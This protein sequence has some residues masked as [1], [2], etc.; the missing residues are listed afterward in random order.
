VI[1]IGRSLFQLRLPFLAAVVAFA[2]SGCTPSGFIARQLIRA[3]NTFPRAVAPEPRVYY[4]FPEALLDA[5]P[6]QLATVGSP[7]VT[8]AY[9]VVPP[10]A[11]D[12]VCART[13]HPSGSGTTPFFRF[14]ARIPGTATSFTSRPRGTVVLLHGYG[15]DQDSMVPWALLLGEAGWRCVLVDLRGHGASDGNRIHYGLRE[16]ED[17]TALMN[18]LTRRDQAAWPA[19]V[20]GVSYGAAVALRW[21]ADD[22]RVHPVIAITPYARL[23]DAAEGLRG[24]Y[25]DWVPSGLLRRATDALP[26]LLGAAPGGLDPLTWMLASPREALFVSASGDRVAPPAAVRDLR[27]AADPNCRL[28]ELEDATHEVAPFQLEA[29]RAPV[30]EWLRR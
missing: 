25:A 7:P 20:L 17:L 21:A 18:E 13:N 26:T 19:A 9:R 29:L 4:T 30:T 6:Q 28:I 16:S 12:L 8:L 15:L 3:P 10:A 27:V 2:G 14:T 23:G 11:Y 22:A 24:E 5:V 1:A